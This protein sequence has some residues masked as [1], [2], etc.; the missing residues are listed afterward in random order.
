[1]K[2]DLDRQGPGRTHLDVDER[3]P[4]GAPEPLPSAVGLRGCLTVDNLESRV[5]VTGVLA[6]DAVVVCDRCLE[7][8]TCGFETVVEIV[9]LRDPTS[10]GEW[11]SWVIHQ[12]S[13]EVDLDEPLREAALLGLPLKFLCADTCRGLCPHCG[14][15]RS[16]ES[17]ACAQDETDPGWDELPGE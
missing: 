15:N 5:L 11:D 6:G 14:A 12:R 9:I 8:F 16:R 17:C 7:D 1:M 2:L 10:E 3:L 4:T 13:G